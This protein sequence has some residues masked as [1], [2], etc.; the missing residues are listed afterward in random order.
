VEWAARLHDI[1]KIGV[2]DKILRKNGPLTAEEWE[3]MRKHPEIGSRIVEP[4]KKLA[5]VAPLI[6]AHHEWYDGTG[7]PL[8][9]KG[10]DIP[11]GARILSIA[12]AY[13]AMLDN[14]IYHRPRTQIDA[15]FELRNKK[16][17]QFDP[18]LVEVFIRIVENEMSQTVA[19]IGRLRSL[20]DTP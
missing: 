6:K 18:E 9:L 2:P 3:S 13:G 4:I 8:G 1:G 19:E 20:K 14:R 5:N 11:L 10:K 7:Y 15:I 17:T 12:D 16:G